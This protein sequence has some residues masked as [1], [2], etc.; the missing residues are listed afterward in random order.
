M[1][2][3]RTGFTL[4]ELLVV[5]GI[6]ALLIS[7]LVPTLS[8]AREASVRT[9]CASNLRQLGVLWYNYS[10][11][12]RGYFPDCLEYGGTWEILSPVKKEA[13]VDMTKTKDGKIF[14]CPTARGY[15]QPAKDNNMAELDWNEQINTG[16]G[17]AHHIGY[18][19]YAHNG[20]AIQWN[21]Y[22]SVNGTS[23]TRPS[24]PPPTKASNKQMAALPMLMDSVQLFLP[25]HEPIRTWSYS[26]HFDPR[27]LVPFGGNTLFGDGHVT[28]RTFKE[29][30]KMIMWSSNL[31]HERW[32]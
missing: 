28:W 3:R 12:Y 15:S 29:H 18:A 20:N 31:D 26:N 19:I 22:F 21:R 11:A 17:M 27:L 5:I 24:L 25:P 13:F 4:V 30:D 16:I 23:S 10:V 6:I 14:Y 7:I 32:W 2:H 8:K 9:K 1:A